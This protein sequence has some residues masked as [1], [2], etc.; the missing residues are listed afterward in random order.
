MIKFISPNIFE[1]KK[2]FLSGL[3]P[4]KSTY[5]VSD[6]TTKSMIQ[7]YFFDNKNIVVLEEDSVLRA[8]EFWLKCINQNFYDYQVISTFLTQTLLQQ[9]INEN[10]INLNPAG[11]QRFFGFFSQLLPLIVKEESKEVIKEWFKENTDSFISWGRWYE[12]SLLAW[13]KFLEKKFI[14]QTCL[15]AFLVSHVDDCQFSWERTLY[16]DLGAELNL[17]EVE[18]I[19]RLKD[20]F[21]IVIILPSS[22][23]MLKFQGALASYKILQEKCNY[24][25][26]KDS[27]ISINET[28]DYTFK[29]FSTVVSEVKD[30]TAQVRAW[31]GKGIALSEI[32]IVTP[33]MEKYYPIVKPYFEKEGLPLNKSEVIIA[34][35]LPAVFRWL[36]ILRIKSGKLS[37]NDIETVEYGSDEPQ[38]DFDL[39]KKLYSVFFDENDLGRDKKLFK[40][41]QFAVNKNEKLLRDDFLKWTLSFWKNDDEH[42]I[43]SQIF[44][45]V[46]GECPKLTKMNLSFWL[47]YLEQICSKKEIVIEKNSSGIN[48][49]NLSSTLWLNTS[50]AY[51]LG[52]SDNQFSKS[53][54][55]SI[56]LSE[57]NKLYQQTG[58]LVDYFNVSSENF[59]LNQFKSKKFEQ[60][61]FSYPETGLA[62]EV[63]AP[64]LFWLEEKFRLDTDTE[65]KDVPQVSL[66]DNLQRKSSELGK[67]N[68][69]ESRILRDIGS[70]KYTGLTDNSYSKQLKFSPT[71]LERYINCPFIY[72]SEK[73]LKLSDLPQVDF[74]DNPMNKG[75]LGH[76]IVEKLAIE[77]INFDMTESEI[78]E[79][80]DICKKDL[81]IQYYSEEF[82][83]L[84]KDRYVLMAQKFLQAEKDYRNIFPNFKT[85]FKEKKISYFWDTKEKSIS[86]DTGYPLTAVIDRID[87]SE[88]S[89]YALIDY[90]SS[91][92][93]ARNYESWQKNKMIQMPMYYLMYEYWLNENGENKNFAGAFYYVLKKMERNKGMKVLG[94]DESLYKLSGKRGAIEPESLSGFIEEVK[95]EIN[96]VI[97]KIENGDFETLPQD[98]KECGNCSWRSVCRAPHLI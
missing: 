86:K 61:V 88:S 85:K 82:W 59:I 35:T 50:H 27:D 40:K 18:L 3:D 53:T 9:W 12:L 48:L 43:L 83:Q 4:L 19:S 80:I 60:I 37:N 93:Q 65:R 95:L 1:E 57:I 67:G 70:E 72:M 75:R 13:N 33:N 71:H 39:F 8:N 55:D 6:L 58:F 38:L 46:L 11:V 10:E 47:S 21:E 56:N 32:T 23:D 54:V 25:D 68:E 31:V 76:T 66:W 44:N 78:S 81:K 49:I 98:I 26:S 69:V 79:L 64:L 94:H 34:S 42:D 63:G 30:L 7:N 96:N 73:L 20:Q 97:L 41:Y 2:I 62:G 24:L 17:T 5:V 14:P 92:S 52:L 29:R 51:V 89:E 77:P 90:K 16:F 91:D 45:Q 74:D 22:N 28:M 15:S 36:S 87:E 84:T